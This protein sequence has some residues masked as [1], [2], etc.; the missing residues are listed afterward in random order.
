M[1]DNN[2]EDFILCVIKKNSALFDPIANSAM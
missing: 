1:N 2:A